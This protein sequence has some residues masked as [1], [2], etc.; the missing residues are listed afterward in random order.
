M[1][2]IPPPRENLR[3]DEVVQWLRQNGYSKH[4]VR[5]CVAKGIFERHYA[6][7]CSRFAYYSATQIAAALNGVKE[8]PAT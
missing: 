5:R 3:Y 4:E 1:I 7:Q 6:S 2:A 8:K